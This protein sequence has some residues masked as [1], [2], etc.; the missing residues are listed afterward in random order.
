MKSTATILLA[1]LIL[2][3]LTQIPIQNVR[4]SVHYQPA[5]TSIEEVK[6][7]EPIF[8]QIDILAKAAIVIDYP[9]G[10]MIF[11]KNHEEP[12]ALASLSKLMTALVVVD[13]TGSSEINFQA[14]ILEEDILMEGDSGFLVD[15]EFLGRELMRAMLVGSSN[16]AAHA[17]ARTSSLYVLTDSS[18]LAFTELMNKKAH[19]LGLVSM[20]FL[21]ETGLDISENEAGGFGSASDIA[22]AFLLMLRDFP[23]LLSS[24]KN[25]EIRVE[26]VSGRTIDVKNSNSFAGTLPGLIASKTGFTDIAGGNLAIAVDI[27]F[28]NPVIIVVLG[29]SESGR[30]DDILKL[31]EATKIYFESI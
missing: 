26:S 15:E 27:G 29:S 17:L 24:T 3:L 12:L 8:P 25:Q 5:G 6:K 10:R 16:D 20:R 23:G 19:D 31:Y 7:S 9:H 21:N 28:Q 14:R 1:L 13:S 30:F 4:V 22:R 2:V 11:G 18:P